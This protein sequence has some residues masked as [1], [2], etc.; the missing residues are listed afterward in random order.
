[1]THAVI[2]GATGLVGGELLRLLTGDPFFERITVLGR[3]PA[4]VEDAKMVQHIDKAWSAADLGGVNRRR[5]FVCQRH[6]CHG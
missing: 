1:M 6:L 5:A 3:R 4:P 2:A